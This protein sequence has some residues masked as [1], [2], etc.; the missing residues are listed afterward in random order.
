MDTIQTQALLRSARNTEKSPRDLRRLIITQTPVEDH[1]LMLV[2]KT[3]KGLMI[4]IMI[5][6][7]QRKLEELEI[8]GQIKT[9]QTTLLLKSKE[10]SE[11][12]WRPEETYCHSDSSE[13]PPAKAD[14]EN[15]YGIINIFL[16]VYM[17]YA[18]G[19]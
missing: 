14:L 16:N 2:R 18:F 15:S 10:Y 6:H 9:L 5:I 8:E 1:L 4:M 11:E 3:L 19:F 7:S 17:K 12:S 13:M